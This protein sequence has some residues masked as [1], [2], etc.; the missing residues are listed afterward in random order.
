MGYVK[1][2]AVAS[3]SSMNARSSA[4]GTAVAAAAEAEAAGI[5]TS[6]SDR[7]DICAL[8]RPSIFLL[9]TATLCVKHSPRGLSTS[10][11]TCDGLMNVSG[12]GGGGRE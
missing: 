1:R 4:V 8:T 5:V 10:L 6:G 7:F 12:S 3:L 9:M 11:G 2:I